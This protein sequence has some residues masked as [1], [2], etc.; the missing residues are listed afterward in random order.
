[1]RRKS[2]VCHQTPPRTQGISEPQLAA[3]RRPIRYSVFFS[4][5]LCTVSFD[6]PVMVEARSSAP[7]E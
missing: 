5:V 2:Q 4:T 3:Q 1:V 7:F 6:L